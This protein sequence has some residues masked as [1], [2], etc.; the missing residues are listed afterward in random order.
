MSQSSV[1]SLLWS[2][3]ASNRSLENRN[4]IFQYYTEWVRKI[5]SQ[6]YSVLRPATV[7]WADFV[8]AASLALMECIDR[9]DH[10]CSVPFSAYAFPRVRGAML[11]MLPVASTVSIDTVQELGFVTDRNQLYVDV[12]I[13][14]FDQFIEAVLDIAFSEILTSDAQSVTRLDGDPLN[15]YISN[16]EAE[17]VINAVSQLPCDLQFI[18]TSHYRNFISFSQIAE[19]LSLSRS[20]VSQ[21]H[22]KALKRLRYLYENT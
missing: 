17:K 19:Q 14:T 13:A 15:A 21:L 4:K 2:Q 1:E 16:A 10:A 20:R 22:R 11:D 5:A 3:Y 7:E 8:Q 9:F 12:E 18:I 6:Q